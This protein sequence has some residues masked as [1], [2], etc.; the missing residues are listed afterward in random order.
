MAFFGLS[1]DDIP[2]P[3]QVVM[4]ST[5]FIFVCQAPLDHKRAAHFVSL[6]AV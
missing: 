1:D 3:I 4:A 2:K 6:I 5:F